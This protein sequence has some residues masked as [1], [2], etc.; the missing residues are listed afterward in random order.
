MD[1]IIEILAGYGAILY[2]MFM[3]ALAFVFTV[4]DKIAAK[5]LPAHRIPEK[6]LLVISAFGG[7]AVMLLTML[8]IRHK[9][10]HAKFMVGIPI[11]IVLQL[12]I[13]YAM[14][15]FGIITA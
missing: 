4:Y 7:S 11:I 10:M 9:T 5:K 8:L 3:S 15:R 6:A 1:K 12:V 13:A 14:L 2:L